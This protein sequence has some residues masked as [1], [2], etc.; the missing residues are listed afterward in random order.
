MKNPLTTALGIAYLRAN[1]GESISARS[2]L[3]IEGGALRDVPAR[4]T[5]QVTP[6]DSTRVRIDVFLETGSYEFLDPEG[7]R[8][9]DDVYITSEPNVRIAGF[10]YDDITSYRKLII[11]AGTEDLNVF[12]WLLEDDSAEWD[13]P[14][15]IM[16]ATGRLLA[17]GEA[18]RVQWDP[19]GL[20]WMVNDGLYS[21]DLVTEDNVLVTEDTDNVTVP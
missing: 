11:N 18:C 5:V 13:D 10:A 8:G 15:H 9:A 21:G 6:T 19:V 12:N 3:R 16:Q 7:W 4:R 2:T 20:L 1:S 17:P 14:G